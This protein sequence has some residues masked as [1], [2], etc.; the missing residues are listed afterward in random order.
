[1]GALPDINP[2]D[3]G[4]IL[5]GL[6]ADVKNLK[7]NSPWA[8]SGMRP[9]GDN[10]VVVDGDLIVGGNLRLDG[11]G[12]VSGT[13]QS[14]DFDGDL[15][16]GNAGTKGWAFNSLRAAIGELF[17]R[18]GSVTNDSLAN[19]VLVEAIYDSRTAFALTTT[20]TNIRTKTLTVP[21]GFTKAA[22]SI[23]VRVFA[24]NPNT[25]GGYDTFGGD[26]LYGQAN[27]NGFN[28]YAL[29]L[30][31]SGNG[32]SG[33]NNSPFSAVL[34]GLSPGA[35]ISLQIAAQTAFAGWAADAQ[36]VAELSGS[37]QWYR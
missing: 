5:R 10:G 30:A 1:M 28:G 18:P 29:P 35:A 23:V 22:V 9:N 24:R 6:I 36:N 8:R 11:K 3:Y 20:M 17:L 31:V 33:T 27:I 21:P 34:T 25:A 15:A 14:A 7:R 37:V 2:R 19:P 16:A 32:G 26:Y 4:Q 13:W 12:T